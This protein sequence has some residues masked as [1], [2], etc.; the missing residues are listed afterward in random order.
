MI[1]I[2]LL[3]VLFMPPKAKAQGCPDDYGYKVWYNIEK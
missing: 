3:L 1:L 2:I